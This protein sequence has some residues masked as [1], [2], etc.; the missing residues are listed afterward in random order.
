MFLLSRLRRALARRDRLT[1][2]GPA[3]VG[4]EG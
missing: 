4:A 3:E 1:A 2:S